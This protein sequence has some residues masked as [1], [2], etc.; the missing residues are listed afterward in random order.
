MRALIYLPLAACVVAIHILGLRL[1]LQATA[2][3]QL[4]IL[5]FV[6]LPFYILLTVFLEIWMEQ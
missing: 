4:M 5:G 2:S 6:V 3:E 1:L